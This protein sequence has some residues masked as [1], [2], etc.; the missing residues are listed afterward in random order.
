MDAAGQGVPR[1]LERVRSRAR[2]GAPPPVPALGKLGRRAPPHRGA[3]GAYAPVGGAW[4]WPGPQ[5]EEVE[6]REEGVREEARARGYGGQAV[7]AV[8][9]AHPARRGRTERSRRRPAGGR[10]A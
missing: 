1:W 8:G 5:E 10:G 6:G 2:P 9:A 3:G 7:R 4:L